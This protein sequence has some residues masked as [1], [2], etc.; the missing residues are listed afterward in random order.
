MRYAMTAGGVLL[1]ALLGYSQ[2]AG[3]KKDEPAAAWAKVTL[4]GEMR[5]LVEV[6]GKLNVLVLLD[7]DM[8]KSIGQYRWD[9]PPPANGARDAQIVHVRSMQV[10]DAAWVVVLLD[11]TDKDADALLP[12]LRPTATAVPVV[13]EGRLAATKEKEPFVAYANATGRLQ[14]GHKD[15]TGALAMG[16]IRVEG[17]ALLGKYEVSKGKFAS[18][19]IEN[20][21]S[22]ILV[23]GVTGAKEGTISVDGRL[24]VQKQGPLVVDARTIAVKPAKPNAK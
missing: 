13:L 24:L 2:E 3:D 23:T 1:A 10:G 22:P 11:E 21:S 9:G 20:G 5:D 7:R 19:A 8:K 18:V 17:K 16:E 4:G 15:A 6:R 14:L 12:K